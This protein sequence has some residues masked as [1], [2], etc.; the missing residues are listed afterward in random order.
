MQRTDR[1]LSHNCTTDRGA[2]KDSSNP[3]EPG[4]RRG[5]NLC[6]LEGVNSSPCYRA[7]STVGPER[8]AFCNPSPNL[9]LPL[10]VL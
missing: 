8:G 1:R 4:L 7:G 10:L 3:L 2:G 5:L 6:A 9:P